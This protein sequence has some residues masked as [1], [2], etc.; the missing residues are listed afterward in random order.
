M[1]E[2]YWIVIACAI[3]LAVGVPVAFYFGGLR[4]K[5]TAEREI[6][7]AED[8]ARKILGDSLHEAEAKKK[9]HSQ[10]SRF[11]FTQNAMCKKN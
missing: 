9:Y 6:G 3:A 11:V 7:S 2:F 8:Q 5:M 4:R 1:V 10:F